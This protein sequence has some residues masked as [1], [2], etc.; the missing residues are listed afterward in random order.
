MIA[1]LILLPSASI[2]LLSG[3]AAVAAVLT[4]GLVYL[5]ILADSLG[6]TVLAPA[7]IPAGLLTALIGAPYFVHLLWRTR[8]PTR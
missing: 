6:R 2:W 8:V 4:F 1:T 3:V 5:V 7:Q